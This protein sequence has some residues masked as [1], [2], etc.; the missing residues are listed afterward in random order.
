MPRLS[1][2]PDPNDPEYQQLE[3]RINLALH[4]GIFTAT[5]SCMWFV[6]TITYAEWDWSILVTSAWIFIL[7]SHSIWV[8]AREKQLQ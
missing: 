2:P 4:A 5:N 8:F 6:R 7:I 1:K 3:N